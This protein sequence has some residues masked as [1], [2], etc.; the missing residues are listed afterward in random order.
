MT[1]VSTGIMETQKV[2][3]EIAS[4]TAAMLQARAEAQRITLDELLL[5][6]PELLASLLF[7]LPKSEIDAFILY[8]LLMVGLAQ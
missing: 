2:T 7:C 8:F 5:F 4:S 1:G 6:L 3:I